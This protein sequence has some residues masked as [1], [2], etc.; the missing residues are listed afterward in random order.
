MSSGGVFVQYMLRKRICDNILHKI[1]MTI[2]ETKIV[3]GAWM[4]EIQRAREQ[5]RQRKEGK[6]GRK[7][8][9]GFLFFS[10]R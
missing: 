9:D 6:A 8:I 3:D 7:I 5:E 1:M 10:I 2:S 4:S